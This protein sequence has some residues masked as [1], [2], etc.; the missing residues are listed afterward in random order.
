MISKVDD[1]SLAKTIGFKV[2]D[3]IKSITIFDGVNS[4]VYEIT[5]F[6]QVSDLVLKVKV[7]DVIS[8]NCMS[9]EDGGAVVRS[10]TAKAEDFK[11]IE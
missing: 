3:V 8:F 6:Y 1:D 9:Q 11:V 10:Y 2:N 7:G 4:V 5:R